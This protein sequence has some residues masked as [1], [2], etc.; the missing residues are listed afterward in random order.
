M[1]TTIFKAF[2]KCFVHREMGQASTQ[3]V[4]MDIMNIVKQ[5]A[6]PFR[7]SGRQQIPDIPGYFITVV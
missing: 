5:L 3:E 6:Q 4:L 2:P 7:V 1:W